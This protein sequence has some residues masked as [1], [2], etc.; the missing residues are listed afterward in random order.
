MESAV[1][2]RF[3]A[4]L[5]AMVTP[6]GDDGALDL[7]AAATLAR[8]LVDHGSDGV[9]IAGTTGESPTLTVPEQIDL[10]G[11]VRSAIDR[12]VIAG[13]GSNDTAAA[14]SMHRAASEAGVDAILSVTPYYNRPSQDGLYEH[15][16]AAAANTDLPVMLYDIPVRTGRKI[17]TSTL[18]RLFDDV[19]NIVAV[20]DAAGDPAETARLIA[21]AGD[22]VE[23]YSG[24][25][26]MTLPLLAVGAVGVVS[27]AS[28]WVGPEM[29]AMV[30]AFRAGDVETARRLNRTMLES[31]D[32]EAGPDCPNPIPAKAMLRH[33]GL[34]VGA[35]RPPMGPEPKGLDVRAAEV[36]DAVLAHRSSDT[37]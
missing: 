2:P 14:S 33:L 8:W 31:F 4:V 12:P 13:A 10:F 28:H 5:T 36:W 24:D 34:P 25:D 23:V 3:G 20:K 9:V 18:L 11:A 26:A 29:G 15:F 27:V 30:A 21:E 16:K 1:S 37:Q 35:C 32:F 17:D 6:F 19:P 7:D 22:R